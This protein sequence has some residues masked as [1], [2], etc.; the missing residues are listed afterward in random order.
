MG[1]QPVDIEDAAVVALR[2]DQ[3]ALGTLTSGYFLDQGYHSH[4]QV[5]G[6]H[7][8]LRLADVEEEPLEWYSTIGVEAPK[9]E[10]FEYPR[11][12]RGYAPFVRAAV[13]ASAGLEE[14]PI[15]GDEGLRVLKTIFAAYR[16]AET[17]TAQRV[18]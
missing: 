8:W 15:T 11:G 5:W 12:L 13:R 9:V 17:G 16:A 10:R 6:Q 18:G 4:I 14:P 2:F 7:G 1:G 3:G